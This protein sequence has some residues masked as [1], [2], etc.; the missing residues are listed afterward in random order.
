MPATS[1]TTRRAVTDRGGAA[2]QTT[3]SRS[4][5]TRPWAR[6]T[7]SARL[8]ESRWVRMCSPTSAHTVSRTHWPSWSQ[9]PFS[10]GSAEVAGHDGPVHGRHDLGQ[11]D[12]LGRPGQHVA[13]AHAPLG[14]DQAGALQ[15]EQDLLEVGLGEPGALGDVPDRGR[16]VPSVGVERQRQERAARVVTSGGYLHRPMLLP[17]WRAVRARRCRPAPRRRGGAGGSAPA[18]L[19]GRQVLGHG[20]AEGDQPA[21]ARAVDLLE[22][23]ARTPAPAP[24]WGWRSRIRRPRTPSPAT[25][26]VRSSIRPSA[27]KRLASRR[28]Q[29]RSSPVALWPGPGRR[30]SA[31]RRPGSP[32][33][34]AAGCRPARPRRGRPAGPGGTCRPSWPGARCRPGRCGR[35][36][37]ARSG[38]TG[39]PPM[40]SRVENE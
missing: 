9:A 23:G 3:A 20:P 24:T 28:P 19:A 29:A 8:N 14:A 1:T 13:A 32:R 35:R 30:R 15:G 22:E 17:G 18:E 7:M 36:W 37:P 34:R 39:V 2:D 12:L 6:A 4:A 21:A 33:A 26:K 16:A 25:T 40:R 5:G 38:G 11:G 10:W 27:P 31:R